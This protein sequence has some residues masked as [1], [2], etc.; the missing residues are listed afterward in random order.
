MAKF[1]Q[2]GRHIDFIATAE[3]AAGT[4]MQIGTTVGIV[5]P[6]P[7]GT[8]WAIGELMSLSIGCVVELDNSGVAFDFGDAVGYDGTDNDAVAAAGGDFDCGVCVNPAGAGTGDKVLVLLDV[9]MYV[10]P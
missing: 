7:D 10:A 2:D 9:N 3:T 4:L 6:K 8:A 1:Y 5:D